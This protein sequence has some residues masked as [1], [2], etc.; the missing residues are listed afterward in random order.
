[1]PVG[2]VEQLGS[3]QRLLWE[4]RSS[5]EIQT[6]YAYNLVK[7]AGVQWK[8]QRRIAVSFLSLSL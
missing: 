7:Y 4:R 8:E 3:V 5:A 2:S 1:M 6:S